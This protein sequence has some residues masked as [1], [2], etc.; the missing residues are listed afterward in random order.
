LKLRSYS[1]SLLYPPS[2]AVS[3]PQITLTT[4]YSKPVVFTRHIA[5]EF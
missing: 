1:L 3:Q 2:I 5:Q 4:E